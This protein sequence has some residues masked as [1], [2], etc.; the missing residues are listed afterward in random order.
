MAQN[1]RVLISVVL[2]VMLVLTVFAGAG[3]SSNQQDGAQTSTNERPV[4]RIG[5]LPTEDSLPL[6]LSSQQQ[7]GELLEVV[8][9][10]SAQELVTAFVAGE[11][12]AAMTDVENSATLQESGT[13]VVLSWITL[14]KT[15]EQ[16]RFGILTNDPEIKEVADLKGKT[17]AGA[18]N[19]VPEYVMYKLLEN[20]GLSDKDITKEEIKKLPVRYEAL[21][22]GQ[23]DAAALPATLLALGEASGLYL[24]ADDTHGENMSQSVLTVS[25]NWLDEPGAQDVLS[26]VQAMWDSVVQDINTHPEQYHDA[27]VNWAKVPEVIAQDYPVSEYPV[28]ERPTVDMVQPVLDW[29]LELGYLKEALVYDEQTG[30]FSAA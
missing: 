7:E 16:G 20:A 5:T 30:T 4:M 22:Q 14:G 24:V 11:V 3:C 18:S 13:N 21:A 17:I 10:Q 1:K 2:S 8:V 23:V 27:V 19:T 25:A 26:N 6:Y 9:F 15:A 12:D 29:M 28:V